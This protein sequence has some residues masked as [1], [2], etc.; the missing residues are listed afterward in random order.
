MSKEKK[1]RFFY[2]SL[3]LGIYERALFLV[4]QKKPNTRVLSYS[5]MP[6]SSSD[7]KMQRQVAVIGECF[8]LNLFVQYTWQTEFTWLLYYLQPFCH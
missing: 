3:L 5:E 8:Y 1:K 7:F 4:K 2:Y 6:F